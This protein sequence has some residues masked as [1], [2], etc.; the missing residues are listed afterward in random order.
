[1]P[2]ADS[3]NSKGPLLLLIQQVL[4]QSFYPS[5]CL[6][7]VHVLYPDPYLSIFVNLHTA[8]AMYLIYVSLDE[9]SS[10]W[11][12]CELKYMVWLCYHFTMGD[13]LKINVKNIQVL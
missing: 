4:H 2:E 8:W 13:L 6:T 10:F 5:S 7:H 11:E 1:M 3:Q 9:Y 12:S